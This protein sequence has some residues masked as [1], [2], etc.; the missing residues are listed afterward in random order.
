MYEGFPIKFEFET[1]GRNPEINFIDLI[2]K[3]A[4]LIEFDSH[5]S[6]D[7]VKRVRAYGIQ[8]FKDIEKMEY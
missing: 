5:M 1:S 6:N 8:R 3:V 2:N 4:N 7:Q